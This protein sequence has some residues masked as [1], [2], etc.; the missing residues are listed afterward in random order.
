MTEC[1]CH[2]NKTTAAPAAAA[3]LELMII[4]IE[5]AKELAEKYKCDLVVI[6][7]KEQDIIHLTTYG[8]SWED[9]LL[10]VGWRDEIAKDWEKVEH[11]THRDF[12]QIT[13]AKY[14]QVVDLLL[15]Q[16]EKDRQQALTIINSLSR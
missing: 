14:K 11:T 10:A 3:A 4:P 2:L 6:A 13:L 7:A 12:R 1:L 15:T 9:K 16:K 5:E 8:V